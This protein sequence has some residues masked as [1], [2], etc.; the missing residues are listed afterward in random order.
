MILLYI[1]INIFISP[2]DNSFYL[3]KH[4]SPLNF[5]VSRLFP[6][7]FIHYTLAVRHSRTTVVKD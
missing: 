3:S 4:D 5:A 1:N 6:I 7:Y 2:N